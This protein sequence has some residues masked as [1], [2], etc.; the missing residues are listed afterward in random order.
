MAMDRLTRPL[1]LVAFLSLL[2]PPLL[3]PVPPLLD[4]PNH[5]ARWHILVDAVVHGREHPYY[6]VAWGQAWINS[7]ADMLAVALGA[8]LG[9][10]RAGAVLL[11]LAIVL[12]PAGAVALNRA[13][14]GGWHWWQIGFAVLAWNGSLVIGLISFQIGI[15][16]AFLL[17]AWGHAR[18][19]RRGPVVRFLARAAASALLLLVHPF[20]AAFHAVLLGGLALGRRA[21]WRG[22]PGWIGRRALA[23]GLAGVAC[24][25]PVVLYLLVTPVP[26]GSGLPEGVEPLGVDAAGAASGVVAAVMPL[27]AGVMTYDIPVDITFFAGFALLVALGAVSARGH[28][29]LLLAAAGLAALSVAAPRYF[30][31]N[32][33]TDWRIGAT[34]ALTLAASFRPGPLLIRG[35]SIVRAGAVGLCLAAVARAGWI[36]AVWTRSQSDVAA[37]ARALSHAEPGARILIADAISSLEEAAELPVHRTSAGLYPLYWHIPALAAGRSGAF[38]PTLF[39]MAGKQPLGV[40]PSLGP[41]T[42]HDANPTSVINLAVPEDQLRAYIDRT[43]Q[44]YF[45]RYLRNWRQDFDYVLVLNAD[46]RHRQEGSARVPSGDLVADEDFAQLWRTG[47][48]R[49]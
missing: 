22:G 41:L 15:G 24:T 19:R 47:R 44:M 26:P 45:W 3:A 13:V 25:L 14:F 48:P 43:P 6:E 5:L 17:A 33:M 2:V 35:W 37:V 10:D 11:C 1:L 36:G 39:A 30:L 8:L 9:A 20:A 29:G 28:A 27:L 38:V 16:L 7:A 12:P 18:L 34:V 31:G 49:G 21:P 32:G 46:R 40:R 4:Y 42:A 23:I